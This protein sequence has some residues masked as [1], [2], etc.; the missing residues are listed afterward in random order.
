[1]GIM[2]AKDKLNLIFHTFAQADGSTTR[3][4]IIVYVSSSTPDTDQTRLLTGIQEYGGTGLALSISKRLVSLLQ[5]KMWVESEISKGSRFFFTI[6]SQ[7]SQS[8]IESTLSKMSLFSKRTILFVDTL[9]DTTG[10]V[11]RIKELGLRPFVAHQ[12][13]EVADKERCPHIDTIVVDS[14]TVVRILAMYIYRF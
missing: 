12:A 4:C 6:T 13:V 14:L 11:D 3:I 8:S 1:M 10:V 2:I 9:R 7:I 5:G